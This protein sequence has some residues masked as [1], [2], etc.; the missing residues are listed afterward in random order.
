VSAL[1]ETTAFSSDVQY[2]SPRD[3]KYEKP[4]WNMNTH[5]GASQ[6]IAET[7]KGMYVIKYMECSQSWLK[8]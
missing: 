7:K 1:S 2:Q 5:G 4:Q 3:G 6:P 8:N